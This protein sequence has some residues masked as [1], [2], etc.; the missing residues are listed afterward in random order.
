MDPSSQSLRRSWPESP[1]SFPH[2]KP[3]FCCP[4]HHRR[5][6]LVASSASLPLQP[7]LRR[8]PRGEWP[9]RGD[10]H[11]PT[12][13]PCPPAILLVLPEHCCPDSLSLFRLSQDSCH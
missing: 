9:G 11:D 7:P 10:A 2:I 8:R 6:Q 13:R 5:L 3:T 12:A 4:L 1:S